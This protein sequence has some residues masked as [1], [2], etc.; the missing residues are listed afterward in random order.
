M[1]LTTLKPL[2]VTSGLIAALL[3]TGCSHQITVSPLEIPKRTE[4]ALNAKKVAYVMSDVDRAKQV[5]SE[6]G[7]GDKI[8]YFPYRDFEKSIRDA[9]RAVYS[10]VTVIK[11]ASDTSTIQAGNI[12]FIFTPDISTTSSSSSLLTWPPTQ[13]SIVLACVVVD[14]SG[15]EMTRFNVTG[16]GKAEFSEFKN[17]FGLAGRRAASDLAEKLKQA[18]QANALLN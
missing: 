16:E 12:A 8:N 5:H 15:K 10:D 7:G 3:M 11:S 18:V 1:N 4:A 6:G 17:D 13:F 2:C 14:A 9:L